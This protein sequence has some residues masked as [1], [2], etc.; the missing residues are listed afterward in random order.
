MSEFRR[1]QEPEFLTGVRA[2]ITHYYVSTGN[3]CDSRAEEEGCKFY[4]KYRDEGH[5]D[6]LIE[7]VGVMDGL[8]GA[9]CYPNGFPEEH[10][11]DW[12]RGRDRGDLYATRKRMGH[13]MDGEVAI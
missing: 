6:R 7:A 5:L 4:Y 1:L 12:K 9:I 8:K 3:I 2:S 10:R 13:R 11:E